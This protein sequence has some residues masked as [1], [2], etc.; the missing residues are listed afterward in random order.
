MKLIFKRAV[1]G[2]IIALSTVGS[3][4]L[5]YIILLRYNT[6]NT[7]FDL[8]SHE[9]KKRYIRGEPLQIKVPW[10]TLL[11][12]NVWKGKGG[13]WTRRVGPNSPLS[14]F[15]VEEH[16]EVIPYWFDAANARAIPRH[17][18]TLIHI[19]GHDDM[20]IPVHFDEFPIFRWPK[21]KQDFK[22]LLQ[23]NDVFIIEAIISGLIKRVVWIW[24]VWDQKN[25]KTPYVIN[26]NQIGTAKVKNKDNQWHEVFCVC[27]L[28]AKTNLL[29]CEYV[30]YE[31]ENVTAVPVPKNKCRTQRTYIYEEIRE[32]VAT[33]YINDIKWLP[34]KDDVILD[35]DEDYFGCVYASQPLLDAGIKETTL[36]LINL[37]LQMLVCPKSIAQEKYADSIFVTAIE[38]YRQ[39]HTCQNS[40]HPDAK[41]CQSLDKISTEVK[42]YLLKILWQ[43]KKI[44]LCA[45]EHHAVVYAISEIVNSLQKLTEKQAKALQRVGFCLNTSPKTLKMTQPSVFSICMGANT[46]SDSAVL[47]HSPTKKDI[48]NRTITL[49]NILQAIQSKSIKFVTLC[50]SSRDGY[51]P[52]RFMT[53][54]ESKIMASLNKTFNNNC[55]AHYDGGLLGGNNGWLS[56]PKILQ[57]KIK[58]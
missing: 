42:S 33:K 47:I 35:I 6:A 9:I 32:D 5:L 11:H 36:E 29:A 55:I 10:N 4:I 34:N 28:E 41:K 48:E 52:R 1:F 8:R 37:Y 7:H 26:K 2:N 46:P 19:D 17:G 31:S 43:N 27:E 25:H 14:V 30:D 16:H 57:T 54:I 40:K 15:V 23:R 13:N 20:A 56:R 21:T 38:F 44:N 22:S 39:L 53:L 45:K 58:I 51:T 12:K 3:I 50:R 18:N 24:P 49:Q